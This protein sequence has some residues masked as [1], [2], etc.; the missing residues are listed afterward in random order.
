MIKEDQIE[1]F[2]ILNGYDNIDPVDW[3]NRQISCKGRLHLA[4]R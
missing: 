2:K 1:A 3:Q 4:S